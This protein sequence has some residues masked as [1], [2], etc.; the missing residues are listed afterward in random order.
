[1]NSNTP[2]SNTVAR[3]VV[4]GFL[5]VLVGGVIHMTRVSGDFPSLIPNQIHPV[6]RS[7]SCGATWQQSAS[8][9]CLSVSSRRWSS[10]T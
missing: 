10:V 9:R 1:M 8:S 4:V 7:G 2:S 6:R 5:M 3:I